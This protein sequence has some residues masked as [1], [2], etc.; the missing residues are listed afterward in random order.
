[1]TKLPRICG[2]WALP[3]LVWPNQSDS[4]D[5]RDGVGGCHV[6]KWTAKQPEEG[7]VHFLISV[8]VSFSFLWSTGKQT[9]QKKKKNPQVIHIYLEYTTNYLQKYYGLN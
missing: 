5:D 9:E 6:C 3:W 8:C 2:I 4:D 7:P 1:M